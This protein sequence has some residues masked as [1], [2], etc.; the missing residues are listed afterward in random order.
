LFG[1]FISLDPG[2]SRN[3]HEN[4]VLTTLGLLFFSSQPWM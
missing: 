2:V 4:Q 3:P 1:L